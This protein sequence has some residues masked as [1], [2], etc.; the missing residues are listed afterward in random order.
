M[1]IS[2]HKV[3][4]EKSAGKQKTYKIIKQRVNRSFFS[5]IGSRSGLMFCL[6]GLSASIGGLQHRGSYMSAPLVADIENLICVLMFN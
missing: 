5:L 6:Q 2:L 4:F 1:Y 3:N